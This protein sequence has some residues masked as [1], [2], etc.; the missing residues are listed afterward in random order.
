M[1]NSDALTVVRAFHQ[2][3]NAHDVPSVLDLASDDIRVGGPRGSGEG[4]HLLEE[5]VGRANISM[6]P[7]RW[8]HND[9]TVVVEQLATWHDATT[10]EE[11]GSQTVASA[12]VIA[13]GR[14]ASIARYGFLG[15]AVNAMN[16]D[17]ANEIK[18]PTD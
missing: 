6:E 11:T 7:T 18:V 17:E 16:M 3:L 15:E 5:W 10:G 13:D 2:H 14:I 1:A 8:F 9:D 4:K 12:F